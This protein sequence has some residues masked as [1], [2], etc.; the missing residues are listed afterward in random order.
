MASGAV[1]VES[2]QRL[3][4]EQPLLGQARD[5]QRFTLIAVDERGEFAAVAFGR[6]KRLP[7]H[8]KHCPRAMNLSGSTLPQGVDLRDEAS[9]GRGLLDQV[10]LLLTGDEPRQVIGA[11]GIETSQAVFGDVDLSAGRGHAGLRGLEV[12]DGPIMKHFPGDSSSH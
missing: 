9:Q 6:G 5:P 10:R 7:L 4:I 2:G 1:E 8:G 11:H 3:R 12:R